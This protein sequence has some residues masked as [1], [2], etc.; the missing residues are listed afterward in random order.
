[1]SLMRDGRQTERRRSGGLENCVKVIGLGKNPIG[2]VS[3]EDHGDRNLPLER[4]SELRRKCT[5]N[6]YSTSFEMMITASIKNSESALAAE[7]EE[8]GG[9]DV[10]FSKILVIS[11]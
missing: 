3:H 11:E 10:M 5:L 1:M 4:G 9:L 6:Q 2:G 7:K 8:E